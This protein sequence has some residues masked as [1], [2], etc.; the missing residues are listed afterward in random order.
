MASVALSNGTNSNVVYKSR[1][2]AAGQMNQLPVPS[3]VPVSLAPRACAPGDDSGFGNY[4]T[5]SPRKGPALSLET[6]AL[7]CRDYV[8]ALTPH[9]FT[10]RRLALKNDSDF[11]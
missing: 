11:P 5:L 10:L 9:P 1:R 8:Q 2:L 3:F 6:P 4:R 7:C